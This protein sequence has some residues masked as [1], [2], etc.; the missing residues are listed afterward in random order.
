MSGDS[1]FKRGAA[2]PLL[3]SFPRF[4]G[5]VVGGFGVF[6]VI[7]WYA[8]WR[9]FLQL[10]PD[11]APV[12][13]NTG[14]GFI[15]L[16]AGLFSLTHSRLKLA[17]WLGGMTAAFAL[18]TLTQDLTGWNFGIDQLFSRPYFEVNRLYPG[19]MSPLT[20]ACFILTGMAIVL[21]GWKQA[22][23]FRLAAAGLLAC[24][25][26]MVACV[27]MVGYVFGIDA[28]YGWGAT[29]RMAVNSALALLLLSGGLLGWTWQRTRRENFNF[30]RWLPVTGSVTLMIMI[31]FISA[32]NM[33]EL[34]EAT[35]WRKHTFQ[36][37]L[38]T[39]AFQDNLLDL[40][41]GMRG[42]V[43]LGD[44]NALAAFETSGQLELPLFDEL[45]KLT[46]DNA[47]QQ[48]YLIKLAPAVG[49][50]FD[51]DRRMIALYRQQ[52][53][54][55]VEKADATGEGRKI[56]GDVRDVLKLFSSAEQK[57]LAARDGSES[58]DADNASHLL[59][60]GSVL[61]AGLLL[62]ANQMANRE[63]RQRQRV[64]ERLR[65]SEERFR[66]AL[67]SAPIGM[68]LVSPEGRWLKVNH[69]LCHM[70]GYREAELLVT[71]FQHI[72]HPDDLE[73]DLD[74]VHQMLVGRVLSY[75]MEKRYFHKN[76]TTVHVLMSVA[77]VR[78]RLG[79]PLYFV[80]QVENISERKQRETER[81]KLI[82]ELQHAL[83]E[84]K[85]LSG[86]IPICG[87]CKSVRSDEGYWQT[88]EQYF[89]A[90]TDADFSHSM[91]P[92]CAEKFKADIV[93]ANAKP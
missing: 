34:K 30:L 22:W 2:T 54:A 23:S 74:F 35:F 57:L 50:L 90:H 3:Q 37:I 86:M 52:G 26:A 21:A 69:A 87:W 29:S 10:L 68:S 73:K 25:V 32:V 76:G 83:S 7:S 15:L 17:E 12:H 67:D 80:S 46:A 36:V 85:T 56:F 9:L 42:Y 11:T 91:C 64:E 93:R 72:T 49:A 60:L 39:Q 71:D 89:Q 5:V 88:V 41:R 78:D 19:R 28:A 62:F 13:F 77:L 16:G 53:F 92:H 70:L 44:T 55:A 1:F 79:E 8:H 45:E 82:G 61:A 18:L 40:Q 65:V 31:A 81:E 58:R 14:L 75:Q 59:V 27:A 84:V 33:A 6:I 43:T 24:V 20:S 47:D 38:K 4:S 48:L 66:L 51:Y 63:L